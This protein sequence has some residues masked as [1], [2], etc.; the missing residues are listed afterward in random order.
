MGL[1]ESGSGLW[2]NKETYEPAPQRP[3]KHAYFKHVA[4]V[5]VNGEGTAS[6]GR[7][8]EKLGILLNARR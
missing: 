4:R 7:A 6:K 1:K 3:K 5:M 2:S 8:H